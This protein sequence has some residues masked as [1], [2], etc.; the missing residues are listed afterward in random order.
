MKITK[1]QLESIIREELE[2]VKENYQE[3]RKEYEALKPHV[4]EALGYSGSHYVALALEALMHD[5][6]DDVLKGKDWNKEREAQKDLNELF[7]RGEKK[8]SVP[9]ADNIGFDWNDGGTSM[10]MSIDGNNVAQFSSQK[11]VKDLISQL[12]ELLQGPM[13]TSG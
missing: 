6:K 7:G 3:Y 8:Q 1:S 11:E 12:E 13:R 10:V 2:T 4:I 9:Y 5:V